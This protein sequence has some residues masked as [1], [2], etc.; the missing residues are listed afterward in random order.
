MKRFLAL[1]ILIFVGF[2]FLL[3]I[4]SIESCEMKELSPVETEKE[5]IEDI[6]EK[7]EEE[8][9]I[10]EL[11]LI[12]MN[13]EMKSISHL[14][15][16]NKMEWYKS[17]K[18]IACKYKHVVGVPVSIFDVYTENDVRL[19]CQAVET[20]CY[21]QNFESKVMVANVIFN[22]L[23]S[24]IYSSDVVTV[25]TSPNQFAYFRDVVPED[26]LYAVL[27]AYEVEDLTDGSLSFHS[28]EKTEKFGGRSYVF[29]DHN[30]G[31]HF[32]K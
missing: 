30:S 4:F 2:S 28:N 11:S 1:L 21:G 7:I 29:T 9:N 6:E 15:E 20:E 5:S 23:E 14:K 12:H 16:T 32:Y 3:P 27:Y 10:K 26:T 13:E 25:I 19:I 22:R 31:H 8:I 24:D 18:K 17:Y